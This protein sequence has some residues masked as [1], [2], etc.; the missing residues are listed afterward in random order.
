VALLQQRGRHTDKVIIESVSNPGYVSIISMLQLSKTAYTENCFP[1][2]LQTCRLL[3][4][5]Y[6]HPITIKTEL[7]TLLLP[8][9]LVQ[10][11]FHNLQLRWMALMDFR[12]HAQGILMPTAG[13]L[14]LGKT[15]L[16]SHNC[17]PQQ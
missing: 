16:H 7:G 3:N 4:G 2:Q 17:F 12:R 11:P 13:S 8:R 14:P 1:Q 15:V 10:F 5:H 6:V 9:L